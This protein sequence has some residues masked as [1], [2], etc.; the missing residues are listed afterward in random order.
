MKK[1]FSNLKNFVENYDFKKD[2]FGKKSGD[3][4]KKDKATTSAASPTPDPGS[5]STFFDLFRPREMMWRTVNLCFQ[6]FSVTFVYYGLLF[7][8]TSLSGDP[9]LNFCL[10]IFVEFPGINLPSKTFCFVFDYPIKQA[11]PLVLVECF[12][13]PY[14]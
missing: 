2:V 1:T 4:A 14:F 7:G 12:Q 3:E 13:R 6:W 11:L 10:N 5:T 8:S 9:Y